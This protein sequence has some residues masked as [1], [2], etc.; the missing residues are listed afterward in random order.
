V[1]PGSVTIRDRAGQSYFWLVTPSYASYP[2]CIQCAMGA[3]TVG[4]GANGARALVASR[5]PESKVPAWTR[6]PRVRKAGKAA[7][8]TAF[9]LLSGLL[10]TSGH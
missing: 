4:A 10:S 1:L 6:R 3:M 8:A 7:G 9:V 2:M 5:I